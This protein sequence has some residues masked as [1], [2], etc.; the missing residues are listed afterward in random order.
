VIT[1]ALAH[2]PGVR[3]PVLRVSNAWL[4]ATSEAHDRVPQGNS[5]PTAARLEVGAGQRKRTTWD[6]QMY[7]RSAVDAERASACGRWGLPPR[8][9]TRTTNPAG[10]LSRTPS[11]TPVIPSELGHAAPPS[12][13]SAET[14]T[15]STVKDRAHRRM[16]RPQRIVDQAK[17]RGNAWDT[18]V[19]PGCRPTEL[20]STIAEGVKVLATGAGAS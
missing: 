2:K 20:N 5:G 12:A 3:P 18:G 7:L 8:P 19:V 15:G 16:A 17:A 10:L 9:S 4:A 11:P 13:L 6:R 14:P 1:P